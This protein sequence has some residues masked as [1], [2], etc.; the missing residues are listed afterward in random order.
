MIEIFCPS[1]FAQVSELRRQD[2][3]FAYYTTAN[4]ASKII[5]KREIWFRNALVMNDY[6]EITYGLN[7]L[8]TTLNTPGGRKFANALDTLEPNLYKKTMELFNGWKTNIL[9][10]TFIVCLSAHNSSEDDNGRL[11]MWRAY[12]NVALVINSTPFRDETSD[13]GLQSLLVHYWTITECEEEL[14]R[15][16]DQIIKQKVFLKSIGE[17]FIK[18]GIYNLFLHFAIGI[19]H[20]GFLEERELRTYII[21][22]LHGVSKKIVREIVNIDGVPQEVWK[23]PLIDDPENGLNKLDIPNLLYRLIVGPTQ[24][25][26][27]ISKAFMELL[28]EAGMTLVHEKVKFSN[29]P[30]RTIF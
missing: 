7:L 24:Y 23:L 18:L 21:P 14:F 26:I 6:S 3:K 22:S 27:A 12:G 10:D 5:K 9:A 20:P 2:S 13:S 1:A 19:K 11:S 16:A 15:V 28:N 17:N 8:H 4:T 25:P 29:I 30:L